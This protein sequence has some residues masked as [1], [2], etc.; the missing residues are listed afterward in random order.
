VAWTKVD[1]TDFYALCVIDTELA[2]EVKQ[3]ALLEGKHFRDILRSAIRQRR[4]RSRPAFKAWWDQLTPEEKTAHGRKASLAAWTKK[5]AA[6][7]AETA[8]D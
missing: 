8:P 1:Q 3:I 6:A 2:E 4:I 5:R 7:T